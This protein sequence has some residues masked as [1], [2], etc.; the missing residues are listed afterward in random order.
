MKS[1]PLIKVYS[2]LIKEILAASHTAT[3]VVPENVYQ[4]GDKKILSMFDTMIDD[5]LLP[6]SKIQG[7]EHL[8]S[9]YAKA[10]TGAACILFVEHYSNID[11]PGISY[12]LRKGG[13]DGAEIADAL[14]AIAGRKLNEENPAVAAFAG[15]FTRIVLC[16]SRYNNTGGADSERLKVININRAAMKKL[17]EIKR[18]GKIVLVF[19]AGTRCRPWD[20]ATKRGVREIDSYI[21]SFDYFCPVAIN[22]LVLDTRGGDMLEDHVHNDLLLYTAGPV[23]SCND[24]RE[25][26]KQKAGENGAEDRKQ[27]VVDRLMDALDAMHNTAETERQKLL[28]HLS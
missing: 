22:G 16:P 4:E 24:F 23:Q 11:L 5:L 1:Q 13:G 20:P 19:P 8:S 26:A 3:Q 27:F 2:G 15:A 25:A 17:D 9:L 6:G 14:V 7:R 18:Q 21:K 12:L 10:K 28:S